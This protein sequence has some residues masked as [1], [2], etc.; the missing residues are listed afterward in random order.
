MQWSLFRVLSHVDRQCKG[1][2]ALKAMDEE[3]GKK[4]FPSEPLIILQ[5]ETSVLYKKQLFRQRTSLRIL[6]GHMNL[7]S[8]RFH[9]LTSAI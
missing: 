7:I 3:G 6:A 8:Q 9:F 1:N 2:V 5:Y 4:Y